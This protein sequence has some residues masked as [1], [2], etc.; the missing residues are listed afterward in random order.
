VQFHFAGQ[1]KQC[2]KPGPLLTGVVWCWYT[3]SVVSILKIPFIS[4]TYGK[5]VGHDLFHAAVTGFAFLGAL[6]FAIGVGAQAFPAYG[7]EEAVDQSEPEPLVVVYGRSTG[8]PIP[9]FVNLKKSVANMRVGPG[10]DYAVRWVYQRLHLPV[11]IIGEHGL[12]RQVRDR[13]GD[14]GWI[15]TSMVAGRRYA[16]IVG[17]QATLFKRPGNKAYKVVAF[18]DPGLVVRL[19]SCSPGWCRIE[20]KGHKGWVERDFLWGLYRAELF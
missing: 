2:S 19:L 11:E 18:A 16:V 1:K 20:V 6:I 8:L 15:H 13:A 3:L 9:R 14:E 5:S 12:W 4:M 10:E 7:S 17:G